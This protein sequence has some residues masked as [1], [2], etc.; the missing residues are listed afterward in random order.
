M[1]RWIQFTK[2]TTSIEQLGEP[3]N[4]IESLPDGPLDIVGDVHGEWSALQALLGHLGYRDDGSHPSGRTLIFVGDLVDRGED[5]PAV[6][7]WVLPK[8]VAGRVICVIGNHELNLIRSDPKEGNGWFFDHNHDHEKGK[9]LDAPSLKPQQRGAILAALN[10]LPIAAE[11]A[12]LRIVHA[13]WDPASL[14]TLLE[15]AALHSGWADCFDHY[16]R[17]QDEQLEAIRAHADFDG[18]DQQ[19]QALDKLSDEAIKRHLPAAFPQLVRYQQTE[20]NGNPVRVLTSGQEEPADQAFHAG[21]KPRLLR[22]VRWWNRY[23][24]RPAVVY[25]H[26]WRKATDAVG[27][28]QWYGEAGNAYCVDFSVGQRFKQRATGSAAYANGRL[29]ALRW[30]E[31][32]VVFDDGEVVQTIR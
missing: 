5:S 26:H 29:A 20:Q 16:H 3:M 15:T 1:S 22:R 14:A 25:G 30:P 18:E 9:F 12:D 32:K 6:L 2:Q 31:A 7:N 27:P 24:D 13:C 28:A 8:V 17:L 4:V 19:F 21:G 11:R 10:R 23:T